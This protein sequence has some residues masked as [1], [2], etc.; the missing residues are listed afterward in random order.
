[1]NYAGLSAHINDLHSVVL[2]SIPRL[3]SV[4]NLFLRGSCSDDDRHMPCSRIKKWNY[5]YFSNKTK[6]ILSFAK[7]LWDVV[8]IIQQVQDH[9]RITPYKSNSL[10]KMVK[11][12]I[13]VR[14]K[15]E[16]NWPR[17]QYSKLY[18]QLWLIICTFRR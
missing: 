2:S 12:N 1:M 7:F 16:I 5:T 18:N 4:E 8:S 17:V 3:E 6:C 14:Y 11:H 10:I 15:C 9:W 13:I